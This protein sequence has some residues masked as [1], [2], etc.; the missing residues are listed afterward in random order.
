[1]ASDALTVHD[2]HETLRL[3]STAFPR[4]VTTPDTVKIW[5]EVLRRDCTGPDVKRAAIE[6]IQTGRFAPTIADIRGLTPDR[7][8]L[9][10]QR[11][12]LEDGS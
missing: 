12:L 10:E 1:M 6:W 5:F 8:P 9:P 11:L 4:F 7:D 2:I 3:L